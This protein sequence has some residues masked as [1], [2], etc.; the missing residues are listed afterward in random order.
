[1]HADHSV[2]QIFAHV[3]ITFFFLYR[4]IDAIPRFSFHA[5]RIASRG[6]PFPRF[7]MA[8]GIAVMLIGGLM[9]LVDY[10]A[11]IG[12]MALIVFTVM[13]NYL[14]HHFWD[15]EDRAMVLNHRNIFCNNIAV[16]GGLVLVVT[17]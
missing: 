11:W 1:M 14:Y 17:G 12:A 13:A 15:M 7:V 2:L 8:C 4:G 3:M 5:N 6:M 16:M 9:V 10:Y